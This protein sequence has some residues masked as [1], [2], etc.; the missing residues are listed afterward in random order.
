MNELIERLIEELNLP[1][2]QKEYRPGVAKKFRFDYAWPEWKI[3]IEVNGATWTKGRHSS[4]EGIQRDY[5][6]LNY[7]QI[8]GWLVIQFS[9]SMGELYVREV[10]TKAFRSRGREG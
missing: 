6:K 9:T 10:I 4:G 5:T 3:A 8:L 1:S 7:C 2:P